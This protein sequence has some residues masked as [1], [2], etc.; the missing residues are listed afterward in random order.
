MGTP[1]DPRVRRKQKARRAKKEVLF[2]LKKLAE[3]KA[4]LAEKRP[5]ATVATSGR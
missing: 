1:Q 5:A 3:E 4:A 2:A